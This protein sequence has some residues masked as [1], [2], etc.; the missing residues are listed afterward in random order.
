MNSL[1]IHY[2]II[3]FFFFFF[4]RHQFN[5]NF[6]T[7][8]DHIDLNTQSYFSQ[9]LWTSLFSFSI[10]LFFPHSLFL[11]VSLL[12]ILFQFMT[13]SFYNILL[14]FLRFLSISSSTNFISYSFLYYR[15]QIYLFLSL[16]NDLISNDDEKDNFMILK[17]VTRER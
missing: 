9:P 13:H 10:H 7:Y 1:S 5:I 2:I 12:F 17:F 14:D 6:K 4:F 11:Y 3:H 8:L 15:F 16:L